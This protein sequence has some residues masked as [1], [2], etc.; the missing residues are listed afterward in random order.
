MKQKSLVQTNKLT[1]S[2][3][4]KFLENKGF[5]VTKKQRLDKESI[6]GILNNFYSNLN[7]LYNRLGFLE[8]YAV[9][10]KTDR[11]AIEDYLQNNLLIGVDNKQ[12]LSNLDASI[13][14]FFEFYDDLR[15][16]EPISNIRFLLKEGS[17]IINKLRGIYKQKVEKYRESYEMEEWRNRLY[18]SE[19]AK[20]EQLR[21]QRHKEL[22]GEDYGKEKK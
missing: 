7:K 20:I 3:A 15:L 2:E 19:D 10:E 18:E 1:V 4:K 22:L 12:A 5:S 8:S 11:R 6:D 13:S 16:K 17:W 21:E 9:N 14:L